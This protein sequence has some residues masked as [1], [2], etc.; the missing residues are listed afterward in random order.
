M[1]VDDRT[2]LWRFHANR[3]LLYIARYR[4]GDRCSN[5]RGTGLSAE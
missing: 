2:E 3:A 4:S 5:M 1:V